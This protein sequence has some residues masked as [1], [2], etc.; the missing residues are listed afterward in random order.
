LDRAALHDAIRQIIYKRIVATGEFPD[1]GQTARMLAIDPRDAARA[2]ESLAATHVVV[3]QPGTSKLWSA[4]PF[5]GVPTSFRVHADGGSWYAPCAWDAF[6][7]PA[8]LARDAQIEAGCAW[9][10]T[11][12][13]AAVKNGRAA[14]SGIVHMEVPAR[15]FWDDIFYT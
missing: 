11:P 4:P 10:G 12:I 13:P 1:S 15:H 6:G 9:S 14:G 5:S 2:Y 7:I 8:A 3:L